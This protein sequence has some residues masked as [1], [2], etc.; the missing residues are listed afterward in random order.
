MTMSPRAQIVSMKVDF[1]L[2]TLRENEGSGEG[3]P[4]EV[5]WMCTDCGEGRV[6]R[7]GGCCC[8]CESNKTRFGE[9][10]TRFERSRLKR[11]VQS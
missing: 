11:T 6:V 1:Q 2:Y 8:C 5:A 3:W 7:D 4:Q 9:D 10:E